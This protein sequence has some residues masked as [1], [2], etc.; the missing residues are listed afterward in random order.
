MSKKPS[1]IFPVGKLPAS[2]LVGLLRQ[3]RTGDPR[4]KIGPAVG[5]DAAVIDMGNRYL[6]A[7][8]DPITL[9]AERIGW[10]AVHIN[11]NDIAVM[12]GEPR[13]FLATLLLPEGKTDRR[14][15]QRIA[16]DLSRTCAELNIVLCGGHT[17]IT[18]GLDRPIIVG[19]MLGEARKRDLVRKARVRPGDRVLL[20][21]GLAIEGTALLARERGAELTKAF[22]QSFV[23]QAAH[24][25]MRPGISVVKA[26]TIARRSADIKA[27][28]DPT[29]GGLLAALHEL[30]QVCG[31]GLRIDATRIPILNETQRVCRHFGLDPLGLLASGALLII[32]SRAD[33]RRVIS[34]LSRQ[35]I[36][37]SD[38]GETTR[39]EQG[40]LLISG[41]TRRKI[42][43]PAADEITKALLQPT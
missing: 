35:A 5:E 40:K 31:V 39:P 26:A 16:R 12:G 27:M 14:L 43:P 28:H 37:C 32:A 4:L 19:L 18:L 3:L 33:A 17:E 25:L 34:G 15:V 7:K 9:A 41:T 6:I 2:E 22:G 36:D 1:R 10:Y 23:R 13:W 8:T 29:E 21:R 30:A 38:I 24:L 20:A 11:A 42:Q